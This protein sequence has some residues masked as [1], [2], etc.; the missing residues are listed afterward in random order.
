MK[1]G[2]ATSNKKKANA[3]EADEGPS[4][5]ELVTRSQGGDMAAFD[6]LVTRYRGKV[7]AMI[8]NMIH[9]EADAWDLAQ[10][11]FVKAWKALPRFEA[12]SNFYTWLYR[13]AH[14]VTYD[15]LRKK[16]VR[17]DGTEFDDNV[18]SSM[19][20]SAPTAPKGENQPDENAQKG[21]LRDRIEAA[22]EKLSPDH[23]AVILLKEVD[24]LKYQEIADH[25]GCSIGTVM[26][27][28]F[29]ARKKLQVL[30]KDAYTPSTQ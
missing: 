29:Y 4:D 13:I 15:W 14:N 21:E 11:A 19:E 3:S 24:G 16:K 22:I 17:G 25:V 1:K 12:R 6:M 5:A 9:N 2:P 10:D 20:L 27:R 30:L 26:S 23:R 7:Y 18:R 8:V 28:L